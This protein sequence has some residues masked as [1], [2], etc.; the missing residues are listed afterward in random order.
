[1]R[2]RVILVLSLIISVGSLA[3]FVSGVPFVSVA[4]AHRWKPS[5]EP[6]FFSFAG[7]AVLFFTPLATIIFLRRHPEARKRK[8]GI[9]AYRLA[10]ISLGC[11]GIS[12]IA[13]TV[14]HYLPARQIT[15]HITLLEAKPNQALEPAPSSKKDAQSIEQR[16]RALD[17]YI[18]AGSPSEPPEAT[19]P[20]LTNQALE[21]FAARMPNAQKKEASIRFV[22][23]GMA[24][25]AVSYVS[26]TSPQPRIREIHFF[27]ESG[28]WK[29]FWIPERAEPNVAPSPQPAPPSPLRD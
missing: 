1:M 12:S 8:I 6:D 29:M 5:I 20:K 10:I 21:E 19:S 28:S 15:E 7:M 22:T 14:L 13:L 9:W 26:P 11:V 27:Y 16:V 18:A 2:E 3:F 4:V 17:D 25:V 23:P 24:I